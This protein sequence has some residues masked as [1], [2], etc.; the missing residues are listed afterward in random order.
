MDEH[1]IQVGPRRGFSRLFGPRSAR[2][3]ASELR[4][5]R[6]NPRTA[7]EH[8]CQT[9]E[10]SSDSRKSVILGTPTTGMDISTQKSALDFEL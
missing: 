4:P 3:P 5:G 8:T 2:R 10:G 1:Q 6:Q 7:S 9:R